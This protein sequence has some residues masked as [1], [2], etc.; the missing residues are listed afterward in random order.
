MTTGQPRHMDHR[1]TARARA[2]QVAADLEI[3]GTTLAAMAARVHTAA[4]R[5]AAVKSAASC[6][7]P[8]AQVKAMTTSDPRWEEWGDQP[9]RYT[10]SVGTT[11]FAAT[12]LAQ[13]QRRA[14]AAPFDWI[15]SSTVLPNFPHDVRRISRNQMLR[16][17]T[18]LSLRPNAHCSVLT[19]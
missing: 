2:A 5:A 10:V 14:F 11:C 9:T 19:T 12:F 15:F 6:R 7:S 1:A 16:C 8:R 13:V 18:L 4:W 3:L 17:C